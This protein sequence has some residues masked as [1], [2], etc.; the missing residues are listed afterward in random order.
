[1]ILAVPVQANDRVKALEDKLNQTI[2]QMEMLTKELSAIKKS[3]APVAKA[4]SGDIAKQL[5]QIRMRVDDVEDVVS[6]VE[7]KVGSRAVVHAFDALKLDLGGFLHIAATHVVG[8]HGQVTS[9]NRTTFELLTKATLAEDWTMFVAQA[10]IREGSPTFKDPQ[11]RTDPDINLGLSAPTV[12]AWG[13]YRYSDKLQVQAGRFITPHGIINIDHFPAVLLDTEQPQFLRPFGGATMFPNF[14]NGVHLY[15]QAFAGMDGKGLLKYH[16]FG[17][18]FA[19]LATE[20]TAG[21]RLAYTLGDTGWTVGG[22]YS[23]GER[24][25]SGNRDQNDYHLFGGDFLFD[26]GR[27][28]W[29]NEIFYTKE[30]LDQNRFAAYTQPAF[31]ITPR[32]I[33]FHR[34]DWLENGAGFGQQMENATGLTFKP[35]KNVHLRTIHTHKHFFK[36]GGRRATNAHLF[37]ASATLSF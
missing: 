19:G 37:Q 13:N 5:K 17:A 15:G 2:K 34:F 8:E 29:K 23:Y 18:N 27:F 33:A 3:N 36:G 31:R 16:L 1:M 14:V 26:R 10:F 12:I 4:G 6:N 22:N 20:V 30:N 32:W 21:G 24:A 11:G 35:N 28:L 25:N 7:E 9:L